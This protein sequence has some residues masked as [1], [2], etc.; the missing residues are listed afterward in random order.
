MA[1]LDGLTELAT[2]GGRSTSN[3]GRFVLDHPEFAPSIAKVP[4]DVDRG[5]VAT[6]FGIPVGF[7][8]GTAAGLDGWTALTL[9]IA[10][11]PF[12]YLGFGG[13]LKGGRAARAPGRLVDA[14]AG[15][16]GVSI[17]EKMAAIRQLAERSTALST[18]PWEALNDL[19]R[20]SKDKDE[21]LGKLLELKRSKE[22]RPIL[23]AE[24]QIPNVED[25]IERTR[26]FE[27][28]VDADLL[29]KDYPR[30]EDSGMV[31]PP[32]GEAA[33]TDIR[34]EA[35]RQRFMQAQSAKE[36]A[37][38]LG[39]YMPANS[40]IEKLRNVTRRGGLEAAESF[41]RNEIAKRQSL[42]EAI[43]QLSSINGPEKYDLYAE[44]AKKIRALK[45]PKGLETI[46][47]KRAT[48]DMREYFEAYARGTPA[49]P[50]GR[51]MEARSLRDQQALVTLGLPFTE[52]R[53]PL[54]TGSKVFGA[55]DRSPGVSKVRNLFRG[56]A[57]AGAAAKA[58]KLIG[59]ERPIAGFDTVYER[60]L[61]YVEALKGF[62]PDQVPDAVNAAYLKHAETRY[63]HD[64]AYALVSEFQAAVPKK[65]DQLLIYR[66]LD[67][68]EKFFN[69]F[70]SGKG[71]FAL[72][73]FDPTNLK[74]EWQGKVSNDMLR[75]TEAMQ[76]GFR[77]VQEVLANQYDMIGF[78]SG[79]YSPR[80]V[81]PLKMAELA[82]HVSY[83]RSQKVINAQSRHFQKRVIPHLDELFDLERQ[84]IVRVEKD[85]V[86]VFDEYFNSVGRAVASRRLVDRLAAVSVPFPNA[87]QGLPLA[88]RDLDSVPH[89]AAGKYVQTADPFLI[90]VA[91]KTM[92]GPLPGGAYVHED[93]AKAM[94]VLLAPAPGDMIG[95]KGMT[96]TE[97]AFDWGLTAN[98]LAK[99]ML[100]SF[101][102]FS[103][104]AITEKAVALSGGNF[105]RNP[106]GYVTSGLQEINHA[107][108]MY[109]LAV[110][111][112]ME[113]RRNVDFEHEVLG[114]TFKAAENWA[115]TKRVPL[116]P[117]A[118]R[119]IRSTLYA[120]DRPIYD[121]YV[122]GLKMAAFMQ[123]F[124]QAMRKAVEVG[125]SVD[126]D[127]I[128]ADISAIVN[129]AF[130]GLAW[131]RY[132]VSKGGQNLARVALTAPNWTTG[133]LLMARDIFA[134]FFA[135]TPGIR[136]L[137]RDIVQP[138]IR[139]HFAR[140]YAL[141]QALISFG[142]LNL[143]NLAFTGHFMEDNEEGHRTQVELP[144]KENDRKTYW[145]FG[146]AWRDV[147]DLVNVT[148]DTSGPIQFVR[149]RIGVLPSMAWTQV[150]GRDIFG[151]QVIS[152]KDGP[153]ANAVDRIWQV[154]GRSL[155]IGVQE[156]FGVGPG[157]ARPL[158]GLLNIAG[159]DTRR[160]PAKPSN[161]LPQEVEDPTPVPV[162]AIP[163]IYFESLKA[164]Q[165]ALQGYI[166]VELR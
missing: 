129:Q 83:M 84:G 78:T 116:V 76:Q 21:F 7:Q 93:F 16:K 134:N 30:F 51:T 42:Q 75:V 55:L 142:L 91:N 50:L 34:E 133:N 121:H 115:S 154:T 103:Y 117:P 3:L 140:E 155:P 31:P 1:M 150:T 165:E 122:P 106:V 136:A 9:D 26:P 62:E 18:Y 131:E 98:A 49:R 46:F 151:N 47:S 32:G 141:R 53:I 20:S 101:D 118:V 92:A 127:K 12:T 102:L 37:P 56:S 104:V 10:T 95:R 123:M 36:E 145:R 124:P 89:A 54:I 146:R 73:T 23:T 114:R 38:N 88:V 69:D 6:L 5:L 90:R 152:V 28:N 77:G 27:Q 96:L 82:E 132:W 112:G 60:A 39:F 8:L 162:E 159:I 29:R 48:K 15:A 108:D 130:S 61:N 14:V 158:A 153:M 68:P 72:R 147:Y 17:A 157:A 57:F 63:V 40:D 79:D 13:F 22:G 52:R 80:I 67:E 113:L 126:Q 125:G 166:P 100:L 99:R 107:G 35:G 71:I 156:I 64:A 19:V 109:K 137:G 25:V 43:R 120:I 148:E 58:N 164:E 160:G 66:M 128:A 65:E 59:E 144:F 119:G 2:F 33:L 81:P 4:E 105:L 74:A 139:A 86:K 110:K 41:T 135:R 138:E 161:S 44:V 143:V 87:E 70:P 85:V 45:P 97:R 24:R 163:P 149:K 94:R 11:D 111:N